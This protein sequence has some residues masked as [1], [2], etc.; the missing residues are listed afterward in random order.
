MHTGTTSYTGEL[1]SHLVTG[2]DLDLAL[3]VGHDVRARQSVDVDRREQQQVA[4]SGTI[5]EFTT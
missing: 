3:N 2:A 4:Y 1:R 5:I